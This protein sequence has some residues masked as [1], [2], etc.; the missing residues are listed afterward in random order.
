MEM[1]LEKIRG[2]VNLKRD[3]AGRCLKHG[4]VIYC[5]ETSCSFDKASELLINYFA[6]IHEKLETSEDYI[7]GNITI[8]VEPFFE[9]GNVPRQIG[10]MLNKVNWEA[11]PDDLELKHGHY[12]L[13]V[14]SVT[15]RNRK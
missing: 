8:F 5:I 15:K 14:K 1:L 10:I 9:K 3:M 6:P 12:Y 2:A 7:G 4:T 13:C 11:L